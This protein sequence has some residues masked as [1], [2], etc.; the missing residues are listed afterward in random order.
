MP[1]P[2]NPIEGDR[3]ALLTLQLY[4]DGLRHLNSQVALVREKH[5]DIFMYS[6]ERHT[7]QKISDIQTTV[8]GIAEF[9]KDNTF[10]KEK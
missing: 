7:R 10:Y 5:S 1:R 6:A 2:I 3:E 4:D 9:I 8:R